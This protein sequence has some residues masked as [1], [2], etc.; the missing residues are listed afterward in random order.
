MRHLA[1][2]DRN[3][4]LLLAGKAVRS[5]AAGLNAVALG[6]TSRSWV[7]PDRSSA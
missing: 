1:G 7:S 2:L 5:F 6:L 3:G 4:R